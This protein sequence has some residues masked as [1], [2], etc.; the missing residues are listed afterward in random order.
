MGV[1]PSLSTYTAAYRCSFLQLAQYMGHVALA[2]S[3]L[4]TC[5]HVL[6]KMENSSATGRGIK[7]TY[8]SKQREM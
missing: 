3:F 2:Q 1:T 4:G 6:E 8:S 7:C 5:V